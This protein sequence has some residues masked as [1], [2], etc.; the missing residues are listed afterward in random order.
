MKIALTISAIAA[1]SFLTVAVAQAAPDMQ[2]PM[3]GRSAMMMHHHHYMH[4]KMMMHKH[5]MHHKMMKKM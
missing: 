4:H 1:A 3:T 5:M 2:E